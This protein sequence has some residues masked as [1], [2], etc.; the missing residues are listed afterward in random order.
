MKTFLKILV[1]QKM[2]KIHFFGLI[3]GALGLVACSSQPPAPLESRTGGMS[4]A[5]TT[6]TPMPSPVI[7]ATTSAVA[8]PAPVEAR[9]DNLN[10]QT[11]TP[12]TAPQTTATATSSTTV[13]AGYY[14]VKHKEN[15]YRIALEHGQN[16]HEVAQWNNIV[17][18]A[19]IS[20]GMLIRISPPDGTPAPVIAKTSAKTA[21]ASSRKTTPNVSKVAYGESKA[22][23]PAA[24]TPSKIATP[25]VETPKPTTA[26]PASTATT[27]A[28]TNDS[29][30][31][32]GWPT[33]NP[34]RTGYS[35]ATKGLE[36]SGKLGDPIRAAADGKVV[37]A[38]SGLRGYGELIIIKHSATFLSAYGHNRAILVKEGDNVQRGQKIAEMG[39]SDSSTIQLHFE[40]RRQGKPVDPTQYLPARK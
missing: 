19:A 33:S 7:E 28:P 27:P 9:L 26:A 10:L 14:R 29:K 5:K 35:A 34:L 6:S 11:T 31:T 15:L 2:R 16:Y 1:G 24:K 23:K 21:S 38:G 17:D 37:Y 32:W 22:S 18:P 8:T 36:F 39:N 30:V 3:L 25:K 13:P 12:T 40:V 20:E 4:I